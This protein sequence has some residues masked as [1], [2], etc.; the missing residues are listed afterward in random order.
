MYGAIQRINPC[1]RSKKDRSLL[2]MEQ[3]ILIALG[4]NLPQSH[5][6]PSDTLKAAIT[7]IGQ[8]TL[9]LKAVSRFFKTPCFPPG[10]GPDYI[11]AVIRL[12][13]NKGEKASQILAILHEIEEEYGR[14]RDV[15]W[16]MRTL[17]LDLLSYGNQVAPSRDDYLYWQQLP[18]DEQTV[19]A[20]ES[21]ILPHPRIQDRGFVLVPAMDV[22]PDWCH[23]VL[24]L[25]ISQMCAALP[26]EARDEVVPI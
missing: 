3:E 10:A 9:T 6:R 26:Q 13:A 18:A 25:T 19:R 2:K 11:N 22:A 23:P 8:S 15:R 4:A 12:R 14:T 21:L 1:E 20:P 24:K 5:N 17:D 16:G 7:A